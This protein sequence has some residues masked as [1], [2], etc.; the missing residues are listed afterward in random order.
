MKKITMLQVSSVV[1][2]FLSL[3]E[4]VYLGFATPVLRAIHQDFQVYP[5]DFDWPYPYIMSLHWAWC[6]PVGIVLAIAITAK[7][8]WCSRRVV[9]IANLALFVAG[10]AL[11]MSWIWG[12]EPHRISQRTQKD[13]QNQTAWCQHPLASQASTG[14][15]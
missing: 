14:D 12:T 9:V 15:Q 6:I 4:W 1:L 11:A 7:D 5:G 2:A 10:I 8:W 13:W 3:A